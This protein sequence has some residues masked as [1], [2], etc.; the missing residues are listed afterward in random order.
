M[1][2][3]K[4]AP[5]MTFKQAVESTPDVATGFRV[6]LT[7]LGSYSSKVVVSET[8][9]LQGSVDIDTFTTAKYPNS[10]RWDYAFAYKGE[11]FFVE[12]HSANSGQVRTV[13]RKLQWLKDWLHHN[14]PEI[15]KMRAKKRVPF[16]WIQSK[17]FAIPKTSP[18]YRAAEGAGLKPISTLTLN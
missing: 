15:N 10:N 18:Q 8:T 11:A 7:A 1:K 17:G 13:L 4:A 5:V 6:G 12:V 2:N 14:A 9:H 3:R 16:Y